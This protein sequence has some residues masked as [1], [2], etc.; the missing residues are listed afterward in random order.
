ME[1]R[2]NKRQLICWFIP[3]IWHWCSEH[4]NF[5]LNSDCCAIELVQHWKLQ[6]QFANCFVQLGQ[7]DKQIWK[8]GEYCQ[9]K[10]RRAR[11]NWDETFLDG[12][13]LFIEKRRFH[14]LKGSL[15]LAWKDWDLREWKSDKVK[16]IVKGDFSK[17]RRTS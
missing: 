12:H 5:Q 15:S 2:F 3:K 7:W 11:L 6:K 8:F 10:E 16:S 9:I 14:S 4:R 17:F 1:T 13:C